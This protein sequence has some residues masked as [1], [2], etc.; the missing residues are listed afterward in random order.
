M[1][2][3]VFKKITTTAV[4]FGLLAQYGP[5]ALADPSA[6]F[7]RLMGQ[8]SMSVS[9]PGYFASQAEHV[10]SGG[11]VDFHVPAE[12]A[13]M[14]SITPPSASAGCGGI[15]LNL[16]GFNI[17]SGANFAAFIQSAAQSAEGYVIMIG[18][19]TLCP[20][21]A[22]VL[23]EIHQLAEEAAKSSMNSCQAGQWAVSNALSLM[24]DSSSSSD[25]TQ[26]TCG[27]A[28][29]AGSLA[30]NP[31]DAVAGGSCTLLS[32]AANS[33]AGLV[34]SQSP[35]QQAAN[36]IFGNYGWIALSS[37]GMTAPGEMEFILS[38]TGTVS[39]TLDNTMTQIGSGGST[40]GVTTTY[41]PPTL[42]VSGKDAHEAIELLM[43]GTTGAS[44]SDTVVASYCQTNLPAASVPNLWVCADQ[45]P[46]I[47]P[48][49]CQYMTFGQTAMSMIAS[50]SGQPI[51]ATGFLLYV[52]SLLSNAVTAIIS[53][54]AIDPQ[55]I[56]L[57][58][59]SPIPIYKIVNI[60]AVYP[61]VAQT[62]VDNSSL[63]IAEMLTQA[64]LQQVL[65]YGARTF[66]S[67]SS[68]VVASPGPVPL[69]ASATAAADS[70]SL[71]FNYGPVSSYTS[72]VSY[73]TAA[74]TS[75]STQSPLVNP[76]PSWVNPDSGGTSGATQPSA[77]S[78]TDT[79]DTPDSSPNTDSTP[80]GS[81]IIS[82]NASSS[83]NGSVSSG[84][85]VNQKLAHQMQDM[86][87]ALT[88]D[89]QH[90]TRALKNWGTLQE[91]LL[92]Q[93]RDID[94]VI[95]TQVMHQSLVGNNWASV[96][97][98]TPSVT[99]AGGVTQAPAAG[100]TTGGSVNTSF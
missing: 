45:P 51:G 36:P 34:P 38:L 33:L 54:S 39:H 67:T 75:G 74:L 37:L 49:G 64:Y 14:I 2:S 79:S 78:L 47:G 55:F 91:Q 87:Q 25:A 76:T 62:L 63:L 15:D 82:G 50:G 23:S 6:A 98:L 10:Y 73:N 3:L 46:A 88:L 21:C 22:A 69:P 43:C 94:Q 42:S 1:R 72:D 97:M 9:K 13:Q 57:A 60:A 100:T 61:T 18:I 65:N 90:S 8:A 11:S 70:T 77:D 12:S 53:N 93:I 4:L 99:N 28:A 17:I 48:M 5:V 32:T 85:A 40:G 81:S 71:G 27:Q 19:K 83:G 56:A 24:G 41:Y 7:G 89:T 26:Q 58:N 52:H 86:L 95:Q 92:A 84:A 68:V 59:V 80:G 30:D 96:R 66:T 31:L 44:S 20:Q 29:T 16:G 35:A